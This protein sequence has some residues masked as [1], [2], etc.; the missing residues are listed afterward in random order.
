MMKLFITLSSL[1]ICASL[2]P[3]NA[4]EKQRKLRGNTKK[5]QTVR[6]GNDLQRNLAFDLVGNDSSSSIYQCLYVLNDL[7]ALRLPAGIVGFNVRLANRFQKVLE[8]YSF[9]N[10]FG[11]T[12]LISGQVMTLE[13]LKSDI[14]GYNFWNVI[15]IEEYVDGFLP[16]TLEVVDIMCPSHAPSLHPTPSPSAVP[17]SLPTTS[18]SR[19]PSASPTLGPTGTPTTEPTDSPTVPPTISPSAFPT[20]TPPSPSPSVAPSLKLKGLVMQLHAGFLS[21]SDTPTTISAPSDSPAE[22]T[23]V[24]SPTP[25]P[26]T[27]GSG[28]NNGSPFPSPAPSL[29]P[30]DASSQQPNDVF[31]SLFASLGGQN[32]GGGNGG[33]FGNGG[34]FG[35]GQS[36][37]NESPP[38]SGGFGNS[39]VFSSLF[40]GEGIG[41][42]GGG[43]RR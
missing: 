35:R 15:V 23:T 24:S 13:D 37:G 8:V 18:P 38:T 10:G 4:A 1:L 2:V 11:Q 6:I 12:E 17:S 21:E 22:E 29:R 31:G 9:P 7:D 33:S 20:M 16:N 34:F 26:I 28:S 19:V 43:W 39:G 30:A 27:P 14:S 32:Y 25:P 3:V 41:R 40:S 36:G 5:E 42:F